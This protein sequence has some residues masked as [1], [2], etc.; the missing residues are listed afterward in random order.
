MIAIIGAGL[1]G[2]SAT[3]AAPRW[4]AAPRWRHSQLEAPCLRGLAGRAEA[5]WDSGAA[6]AAAIA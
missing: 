1:A 5:A 6:L 2:L 4:A 3:P